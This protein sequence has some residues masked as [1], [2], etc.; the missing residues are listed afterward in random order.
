MCE[1]HHVMIQGTPPE[2]SEQNSHLNHFAEFRNVS[3]QNAATKCTLCVISSTIVFNHQTKVHHWSNSIM[4]PFLQPHDFELRSRS[5]KLVCNHKAQWRLSP[6]EVQK[7]PPAKLVRKCS[8][9]VFFCHKEPDDFMNTK[10]HA[11]FHSQNILIIRET[12]KYVCLSNNHLHS[13]VHKAY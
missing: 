10:T 12:D 6:Y 5:L 8:S 11:M 7:I 4:L 1:V 2:Q 13:L 3:K 9:I